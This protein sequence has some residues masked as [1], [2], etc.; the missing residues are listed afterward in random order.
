MRG[1]QGAVFGDVAREAA[2]RGKGLAVN[3][4]RIAKFKAG[5]APL[6]LG[7]A[8]IAS[9]AYAQV[10]SAEAANVQEGPAQ[11]EA[12]DIIVTGSLIRNPNVNSSSQVQVI[13]ENE[14][15]LRAPVTAEEAVRQIPGVVPGIGTQVNNGSNG[16][17][18]IDLRGLGLQ[19]NLVLLDGNRIVPAL[20]NGAVDLNNIPVALL[21]RVDVLTGGASTTYGADAVSGVVNFI[22]RSDFSGIDA[23]AGYRITERGDGGT[24]RADLTIGGNF[25]DDRGNAVLS[26][27]YTEADPIYQGARDIS[28]FGISSASGRASGASFT[29]VPTTFSFADADLQL[30]PTATSLVPQYQ[31]FNF[32]PYNI[33]QT[34]LERKSL[35]GAARFDVTD[36]IQ[37][38]ARAMFAQTQIQSIIAP[39]GIFGETLNIPANNPYLTPALR[40]QL[41]AAAGI[42][43][44]TCT[45][46]TPIPVAVYRRLV[47]LGPRIGNYENNVWDARGGVRFNVTDNLDF[48]FSASSG[49]SE[50]TQTNSGYVLRS[51]VQQA[52][53]ASTTTGCTVT[54]GGCVP[55]NLFGPA[56]SITPAQ[57]AFLQGQSTVRINTTLD[58]VRGILSGDFGLNF[59]VD[60]PVSFALGAEYRD[61]GY[62]RVPDAFAASPGELGG[63]GG[64][65][66]AFSGG[67]KVKE[68][69]GEV[70]AP[71][72]ADRPFFNTL[73]L[74]AGVRYS[75]YDVEAP[76]NPSFE[77]WTY[78]GGATW[79]PFDGFRVRGIY[80]RAVRAPNIGELFAP[81]S[82]GLTNL[83]VDPCAGAAPATNPNLA[84]ICIAQGAPASAI[85][86]IQNPSSGQSNGTGGG[87]PNIQPEKADTFTAGVVFSPRAFISGLTF[88]VDYYNIVVNDA[89][90]AQTPGDAI[91]ACFASITAA[92]ASSPAC[93]AIRRNPANGRLSG[94]ASNT[95]G[96]ALPL[97]NNGR[98]STA[99]IDFTADYRRD[100]GV[101]D[102]NLNFVGNWTHHLRFQSSPS[103]PTRECVGFYSANCGPTLGQIQPEFSFQQRT[104]LGFDGVSLSLLWRHIDPV[105]YEPG[106]RPLFSGTVTNAPGASS[107]LTGGTYDF[108]R[109]K[110][111]DYFDLSA[112]FE[113][114]EN[115]QLTIGAFNLFDRAPP[116][117][118]SEAGSTSANSGNTFPSTYDTLGRSYSA[119][120]RV[121]F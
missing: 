95:P 14:L 25:A 15:T 51:R 89:I 70:I 91:D 43:A 113:I 29:S 119:Q 104:T 84:A 112:Q 18:S 77:T 97:T 36:G 38:Y 19:R 23:R 8:M 87:N 13:S 50:Q 94:S 60:Q 33:F 69:F 12:G 5:S 10:T 108:N 92:S 101:F 107:P 99:G 58:Q 54:T 48:D 1:D 40:T 31:G 42:A 21:S 35:Y 63:S 28:L 121:R 88:S 57:V 3:T 85:G 45:G 116:L 106:L 37:V 109:I 68:L 55:L 34:P 83:A 110:A 71:L 67:Y 16:T 4:N 47:E 100:F 90:T 80:Q 79:E 49:R 20:S 86:T 82:T 22:T 111:Y 56:G 9:P 76:G 64:A 53:N 46:A 65:V 93:L 6:V 39:S 61:Y 27:G 96:L 17:N 73:T 75:S 66:T 11:D 41:C 2:F 120:V 114:N 118:G 78:K 74:E 62:Q 72:L 105:R 7:L 102:L 81:V 98:L 26:M 117:V 24:F 30:D 103:A 52:L 32:N 115:F 44:A 59:V